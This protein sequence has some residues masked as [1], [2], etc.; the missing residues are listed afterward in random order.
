MNTDQKQI[1]KT[2]EEKKPEEQK[3]TSPPPR[4]ILTRILGVL[5]EI[6]STKLGKT[7]LIILL[8]APLSLIPVSRKFSSDI[9]S[10]KVLIQLGNKEQQKEITATTHIFLKNLT[11]SADKINLLTTEFTIEET[12]EPKFRGINHANTLEAESKSRTYYGIENLQ[13]ITIPTIITFDLQKQKPAIQLEVKEKRHE[14]ENIIEIQPPS[15]KTALELTTKEVLLL[16][17]NSR[18]KYGT[19][20][21]ETNGKRI[22]IKGKPYK[23]S[24]QATETSDLTGITLCIKK[25]EIYELNFQ[26]TLPNLIS[27]LEFYQVT[28]KSTVYPDRKDAISIKDKYP[29]YP[30]IKIEGTIEEVNKICLT[31]EG[32]NIIIK[33]EYSKI[34]IAQTEQRNTLLDEAT[35]FWKK[36]YK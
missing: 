27:S 11:V 34:K 18:I 24:I 33:G 29:P 4:N 14:N 32:I 16:I 25:G 21:A 17:H 26:N 12:N 23:I 7:I 5:E 10:K 15:G 20:T 36:I 19:E 28:P 31:D 6:W 9:T 1:P 8:A 3:I 22:E 30:D 35:D 2:I 13:S